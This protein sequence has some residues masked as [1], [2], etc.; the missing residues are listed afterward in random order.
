MQRKHYLSNTCEQ[1][2]Q[3]YGQSPWDPRFWQRR[4]T[5]RLEKP[6]QDRQQK[7]CLSNMRWKN[8]DARFLSKDNNN[9]NLKTSTQHKQTPNYGQTRNYIKQSD[10]Q[11][12]HYLP[13]H[14]VTNH[15]KLRPKHS[16]TK[17]DC[18]STDRHTTNAQF[19]MHAV[20]KLMKL[21]GKG[22][23]LSRLSRMTT[24]IKR[25]QQNT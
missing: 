6:T 13:K 22:R 17:R 9:I 2:T 10:V 4:A 21:R 15:M 11:R 1:K 19:V 12:K 3:N 7:H 24:F 16:A 8:K 25:H 18:S 20:P 23:N 5:N 14:A